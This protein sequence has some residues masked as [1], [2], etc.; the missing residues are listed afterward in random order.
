VPPPPP[1]SY[2]WA[3]LIGLEVTDTGG[4]PLGQVTGLLENGAQDVLVVRDSERERLIPFVHGA[5]IQSVDMQSRRIVA[6]WSAE[7]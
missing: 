1:G 5:I 6:D 4:A 3:D 7:Y 2:Y